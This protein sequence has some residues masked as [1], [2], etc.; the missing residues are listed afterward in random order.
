MHSSDIQL[1]QVG[2]SG[3]GRDVR[4]TFKVDHRALYRGVKE[5]GHFTSKEKVMAGRF[6]ELLCIVV[7][8]NVVLKEFSLEIE[9]EEGE[10]FRLWLKGGSGEGVDEMIEGRRK[11][12]SVVPRIQVEESSTWRMRTKCGQCWALCIQM[13][14][15][16]LRI[17]GSTA[18]GA[19]VEPKHTDSPF[20][21]KRS[22]DTRCS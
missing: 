4:F 14:A 13:Q 3:T 20:T 6:R 12:R 5:E 11:V 17:P 2:S 21:I 10:G 8:R 16:A 7:H 18:E 1:S 22:S 15:D 19:R 9:D